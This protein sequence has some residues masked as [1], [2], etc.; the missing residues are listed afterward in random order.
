VGGRMVH[1][2]G[3]RVVLLPYVAGISATRLLEESGRKR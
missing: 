2:W 1:G 3:G